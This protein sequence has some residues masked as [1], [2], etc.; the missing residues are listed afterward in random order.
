MKSE[1]RQIG[2]EDKKA[3]ENHILAS[4]P[5]LSTAGTWEKMFFV[6]QWLTKVMEMG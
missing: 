1:S 6:D 4:P 2:M 3:S 5:T